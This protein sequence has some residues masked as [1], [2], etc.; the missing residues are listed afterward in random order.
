MSTYFWFTD[1][2]GV[3]ISRDAVIKSCDKFERDFDGDR[4]N[5]DRTTTMFDLLAYVA[6]RG[7]TMD[8][9]ADDHNVKGGKRMFFLLVW[10][11]GKLDLQNFCIGRPKKDTAS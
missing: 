10:L 3:V 6:Q 7:R 1:S 2:N 9:E 5:P 4:Y 11:R 8:Q